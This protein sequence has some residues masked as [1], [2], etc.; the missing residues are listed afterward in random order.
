MKTSLWF[1]ILFLAA[2]LILGVAVSQAEDLG[3]V[4]AR[5][6][7]RQST[8]DALKERK[9]VGEN[10]RG[11]LEARASLKP[12]EEKIVS[13]ENADRA[14]VYAA[15]AAQ[16]GSTSDQVGR[17]RATKIAA[18]SRGGVWVQS[19]QGDWAVK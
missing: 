2:A 3:A 11:Y 6:D 14:T 4:K 9:L 12:E 5:M 15:I 18:S 16:T 7:Q 10:N 17:L 19:P 8:V 1:R 13:D